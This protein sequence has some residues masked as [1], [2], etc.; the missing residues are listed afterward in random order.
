MGSLAGANW[1]QVAI[2]SSCL[3]I[4]ASVFWHCRSA[5]NL[6]ALGEQDAAY[7]GLNVK[8][9]KNLLILNNF[10]FR[11]LHFRDQT[12]ELVFFV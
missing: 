11:G 5:L 1:L 8:R 4:S 6:F 2:L 12:I 3:A 10:G 9:Y 7:Q